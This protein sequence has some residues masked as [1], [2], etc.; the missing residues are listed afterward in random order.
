[1]KHKKYSHAHSVTHGHKSQKKILGITKE[2]FTKEKFIEGAIIRPLIMMASFLTFIVAIFLL[3]IGD[4]KWGGSFIIFS[5]ILNLNSIYLS[6][7]DEISKYRNAN[8]I[9]KVVLFLIEIAV[10]NWVGVQTQMYLMF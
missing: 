2:H 10:F 3:L 4:L 9:F 1:M 7:T 5:F 8:L 6:L